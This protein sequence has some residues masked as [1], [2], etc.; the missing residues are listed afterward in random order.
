MSGQHGVDEHGKI[1]IYFREG[2]RLWQQDPESV[3]KR[4]FFELWEDV[5]MPAPF[6]V[7]D[8]VVWIM[9]Q[10]FTLAEDEDRVGC[11][12]WDFEE[13][14]AALVVEGK[15]AR[16][17]FLLSFDD[18][19]AR[20]TEKPLLI[21]QEDELTF[22][23]RL[24]II[25]DIIAVCR[26]R[27]PSRN[28]LTLRR[29]DYLSALDSLADHYEARPLRI[30][31][32]LRLGEIRKLIAK[33]AEDMAVDELSDQL[34]LPLGG[35]YA[36]AAG[37]RAT[38]AKPS[39]LLSDA[40]SGMQIQCRTKWSIFRDLEFLRA[41]SM[42]LADL[43][44]HFILPIAEAEVL[45]TDANGHLIVRVPVDAE[46]PLL[47]GDRLPVFIRG[48]NRPV[49]N[50]QVDLNEGRQVLGRLSTDDG[51]DASSDRLYARPRR[52][53]IDFLAQQASLLVQTFRQ[54]GHL[55]SPA[56][57]A[58]LGAG[59][60]PFEDRSR[61]P[62][63]K[64]AGAL[65][66]SQTHAW[67]NAVNAD[68]P[69]V[70]VQGPPGTGKTHV[71]EA[72]IRTLAARGQRLLV[73]APSNTAVDN[74]CQRLFDL[75]VL[76]LGIDKS[77][78]APEV[79]RQLWIGDLQAVRSF[80]EK[81]RGA[82]SVFAGTPVGILRD[83][84]LTA[85]LEKNGLCDAIIF[86]EAGM[87]RM[88]EFLLCARLAKRVILFGDHQQLPPFPLPDPAL[89]KLREDGPATPRQWAMLTRSA[90][91]YL[92]EERA[93]PVSL[94][95]SSYRCQNPRLMRFSSTLFYNARVKA[96]AMADYYQL[97]FAERLAR[98]PAASLRFCRTSPLPLAARAEQLSLEG[99]RPG[100]ENALE[101]GLT[102][103]A[104]RE[105]LERYEPEE[106]T[107]ISPYRR[108][109]RLLRERLTAAV[110]AG[111]MPGLEHL[112]AQGLK[113]LLRSRVSTVD[114]FQGGESD[115]VIVCFVRSNDEGRIGFVDDPNRINVALTRCRREM[116]LIGD[117]DC[118]EANA[119]GRIFERMARA[120]SR[121]GEIVDVSAAM[122]RQ[123]LER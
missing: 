104:F 37:G 114:S 108:Q 60:L 50:F 62:N 120:I 70:L 58:A 32:K 9:E 54:D 19:E 59:A 123:A 30:M 117:L 119:R 96:N 41:A 107:V 1:E 43:T 28:I 42:A 24:E 80:Q 40:R 23:E 5:Q 69:V 95:Q 115:A 116:I 121:D 67:A 18:G 13:E 94:L 109:V 3:I 33:A 7:A 84:I 57:D 81:R 17:S 91:E 82:E 21:L 63:D 76:R 87:V 111:S 44:H 8:G 48:E 22:G 2:K 110:E 99:Q 112:D 118:L 83:E 71:L 29:K 97:S 105:L 92:A 78:L 34:A 79:A 26:Q 6:P 14:C 68:N 46:A 100:L 12:E 31:K 61:D 27:H 47:E 53:P 56:A 90:L 74:V 77:S 89:E 10:D 75:P 93:V 52:G 101:A 4:S 49:G 66:D 85:D 55:A 122:A 36:M 88:D 15:Q 64:P 11:Y 16:Q 103:A 102:V 113:D 65:D 25:F 106:L 45:Q 73:A 86:D 39:Y 98:Y 51:V 38:E 35:S 72:V 20:V